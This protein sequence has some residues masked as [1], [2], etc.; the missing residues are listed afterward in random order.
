[1]RLFKITSDIPVAELKGHTGRTFNIRWH[2]IL[3]DVLASGSDDKTIRVWDV[4]EKHTVRELTGH[5]NLVRALLWH[6]ECVHIL[7]SGSWDATIR[8]WN[9]QTETCLHVCTGHHADVY[10]IACH[11]SRP[12]LFITC[13][14]DTSLRFWSYDSLGEK[15]LVKALVEGFSSTG[16]LAH[17]SVATWLASNSECLYGRASKMLFDGKAPVGSVRFYYRFVSFFHYRTGIDDLWALLSACRGESKDADNFP[18]SHKNSIL[19]ENEIVNAHRSEALQLVAQKQTIGITG[20]REDRLITAAHVLLRIGDIHGYCSY[21]ALANQW[22]K[23]ICLA[24]AVSTEFWQKCCRDYLATLSAVADTDIA[25]P[26]YIATEDT[27]GYVDALLAQQELGSALLVAKVSAENSYPRIG[28]MASAPSAP[29][30]SGSRRNISTVAS[31][32]AKTYFGAYD[33]LR[34]ALTMLATSDVDGALSALNRG[35]EAVLCYVTAVCLKRTIPNWC[36]E[37]LAYTLEEAAKKMADPTISPYF[38]AATKM[39]SQHQNSAKIDFFY[40]RMKQDCVMQLAFTDPERATEV[41]RAHLHSLFQSG[42]FEVGECRAILEPFEAV[43]VELLPVRSIAEILTCAAYIGFL[44][45]M[46]EGFIDIVTPLAQTF[47]N[48]ITHQQLAFPVS[49]DEVTALEQEYYRLTTQAETR[50]PDPPTHWF[51]QKIAHTGFPRVN[52]VLTSAHLPYRSFGVVASVLT[53]QVIQGVP[54]AL[55]GKSWIS[56]EE[57]EYWSRVNMFSPMNT[58]E[59][60]RRGNLVH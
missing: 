30:A 17:S 28:T 9:V 6:S 43:D 38:S 44:E 46:Q 37:R 34:A 7:I 25:A 50:Q 13:S 21:M 42:T 20:K 26:L 24:P 5:V 14:R 47:R 4:R 45:A 49:I 22:E 16:D 56:R 52:L 58:G 1:V 19:H 32:L 3:R 27:G 2:P 54:V 59:K 53:S 39:W 10:G 40:R 55:D 31:N 57:H 18:P 35:C 11:P 8:V 51:L 36:I 23:A 48:L 60:I 15:F 12:F 29:P 41:A 33:P